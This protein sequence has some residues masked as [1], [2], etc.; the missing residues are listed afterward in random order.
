VRGYEIPTEKNP[1]RPV[2]TE[3][4]YRA[5]CAASD[6]L[7][8]EVRW[9]GHRCVQRAHLSK[10]LVIANGTARRI[11][12]T[13]QL[14][15]EDLRLSASPGAPHGAILPAA[16]TPAS[17]RPADDEVLRLAALLDQHLRRVRD[18]TDPHPAPPPGSFLG[19]VS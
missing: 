13:C 8:M 12:A 9:D 1:R 14:R 15:Y 5:L 18:G 4:R 11:S 7:T 16:Y 17:A 3:D 19:R 2:A 10:L 6:Q